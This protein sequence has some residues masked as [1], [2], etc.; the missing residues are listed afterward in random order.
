MRIRANKLLISAAIS[1]ALLG[2]ALFSAAAIAQESDDLEIEEILVT[3]QKRSESLSEVP[4]AITVF[5]SDSID[6]TGVQE[7]RD[8]TE[9]IP[10]VTITQG[11]DFGAQINIRGVG[12][13]ARN[14]GFDSRVGVYLDGV[15]LGQG[16]ALNQDLVDLDQVL[17]T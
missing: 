9:Y 2:S 6:Q 12:A 16:P 8:L 13:N 15:Y 1:S 17:S 7:L 10:N 3:A 14:I 11:S 5:S 4:I